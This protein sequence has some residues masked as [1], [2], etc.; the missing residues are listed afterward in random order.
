MENLPATRSILKPSRSSHSHSRSQSSSR[1]PAVTIAEPATPQRGAP[2]K[3]AQDFTVT[4]P[5]VHSARQ[6]EELAFDF[7][8]QIQSR[9]LED[10]NGKGKAKEIAM[11]PSPLKAGRPTHR[12]D[13]YPEFRDVLTRPWQPGAHC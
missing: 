8:R 7:A 10:E 12:S 3:P 5:N 6:L 1:K 2:G 11:A 13:D 9:R 4:F